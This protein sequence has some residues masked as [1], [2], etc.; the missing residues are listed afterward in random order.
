MKERPKKNSGKLPSLQFYPADWRKD[1]AVQSLDYETRGVWFEI[2]CLMHES[3][4][5]G[6]L[7]LNGQVMPED[8]LARLLGLDKQILTNHLTKLVTYGVAKRRE[9]D[10]AIFNKR[11]VNDEEL[12]KVRQNAGKKGGNPLLVKQK[13]TTQDKQILT[14]SSSSSSSSSDNIPTAPKGGS[15]GGGKEPKGKPGSPKDARHHEFIRAFTE[16]WELHFQDKY[17]F[18]VA[19]GVAVA[20]L[21][22]TTTLT[23]DE[24]MAGIQWC[25]SEI[26]NNQRAAWAVKQAATLRGFCANYSG[27]VSEHR[28]AQNRRPRQ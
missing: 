5:R 23:V 3:E 25:W 20:T 17:P 12:R 18:K 8:A 27:I 9:S 7:L 13:Q 4:E 24:L 1:P 10:G 21:L 16:A 6:V 19:D 26:D 28:S 15:S 11:M 2:L 14:P 22:K